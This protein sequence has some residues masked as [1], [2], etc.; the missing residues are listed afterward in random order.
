VAKVSQQ[1]LYKHLSLWHPHH[2][3][4]VIDPGTSLSAVDQS[5]I[6]NTAESSDSLQEEALHPLEKK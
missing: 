4:G 1:T 2:Q 5:Q 3:S 6:E